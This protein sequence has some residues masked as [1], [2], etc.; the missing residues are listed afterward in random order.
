M[1]LYTVK[2]LTGLVPNPGF[3]VHQNKRTGL[4]LVVPW[5]RSI[6]GIATEK[7]KDRSIL[8]QGPKLFNILPKDLRTEYENISI[9]SFKHRLD[10]FLRTIPDQPTVAGLGRAADSNSIIDQIKTLHQ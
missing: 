8:V 3:V 1:I 5:S 6:S 2:A 4:H 10:E 9:E 7:M